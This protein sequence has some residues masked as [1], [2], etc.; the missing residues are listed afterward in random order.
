VTTKYQAN[1]PTVNDTSNN[2]K[3]SA[4]LGWLYET[5]DNGGL[6]TSST[7][8]VESQPSTTVKETELPPY[9][10]VQDMAKNG[11]VERVKMPLQVEK[12]TSG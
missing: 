12:S 7:S 10:E 5:Q 6:A 11:T 8:V 9:T 2:D 4:S 1:I 3:P